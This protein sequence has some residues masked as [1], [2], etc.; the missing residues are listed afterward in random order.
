MSPLSASSTYH[1]I[2]RTPWESTPRRFAHTSTSASMVAS[3]DGIPT[4]M[5]TSRVNASSAAAST[6]ISSLAMVPPGVGSQ[7]LDGTVWAGLLD[8]KSRG[9][10]RGADPRDDPPDPGGPWMN[11][12]DLCHT[13]ATELARLYRAKKLSPVEVTDAVLARI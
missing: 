7:R 9:R 3:S 5:N 6:R 10:I 4:R 12:T 1:G 2:R 13:P 8:V 11:A